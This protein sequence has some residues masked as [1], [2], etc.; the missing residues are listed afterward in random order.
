MRNQGCP[1][2]FRRSTRDLVYCFIMVNV[3]FLNTFKLE[4]PSDTSMN[5]QFY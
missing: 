4:I 2:S 5:K 1:K 3:A